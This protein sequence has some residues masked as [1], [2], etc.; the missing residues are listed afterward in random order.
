VTVRALRAADVEPAGSLLYDQ[1]ARAAGE[2]GF[3]PPWGS[4]REASLLVSLYRETEPEGAVVQEADDGLCG[5]GFVRRRGEIASLGPIAAR[6]GAGA[7]S[8]LVEELITRAEGWGCAAIRLYQDA[9]NPRSF[10]LCATHGF[11]VVDVVAHVTRPAVQPPRIDAA[12]GL[13]MTPFKRSDLPELVG[14]DL[15]LTGLERPGDLEAGVKLVA[16]RRGSVVGFLA[17]RGGILGPALALDVADLFALVARTIADTKEHVSARLSTAAP[18]ALLAAFALGFRVVE[19]G[20]I[21][22]RGVAPAARPPQLYSILP[23]IL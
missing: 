14:L 22:S 16:R 12:R 2:R 18:T 6:P 15:R 21:M 1:Y 13:E 17:S 5:V 9:W 11:A 20:T 23:E 4:A 19:V 10:A 3:P 8:K 7:G